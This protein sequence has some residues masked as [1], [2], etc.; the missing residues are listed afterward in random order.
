MS[1]PGLSRP[2]AVAEE[3]K[4]FLA[5][6]KWLLLRRLSQALV[7]AVF[8]TGPLAGI[9]IAKGNL[10]SSLTLGVLPLT[11]PLTAL[12][13][14]A[15]GHV[16]GTSA[17]IGAAVVLA[18][19]AVIGG[20]MYCSWI[21]PVNAVTDLAQWLRI[22]LGLDKGAAL[23]RNT[24][25]WIL[26]GTLAASA[27]TGTIAWEMVNPVTML[28]RG[29][30]TGSIL[31]FGSAAA[32][33]LAVFL[34]DLGIAQRGWCTHLCPVGAFYGLLGRKSLLRV[35]ARDRAACNDCMD[36]FTVC[37]E[38]HVIVPA[39]KGAAKGV[40]PVILSSDCTNCGRCIDVCSKTVFRFDARFRNTPP[41]GGSRAA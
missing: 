19:Y 41:E 22:R 24:R 38:R 20:R 26:A 16:M 9:W 32:I 34:F 14:L 4:G 3:T 40:G 27:V 35:S 12:Q 5:A 1:R 25:Y 10:A 15:A 31:T 7:V 21:C 18:V 33:T 6:R 23:D 17:L 36:C 13:S 29:L 8:L 11:D 39:L 2:G 30:V 37:P 28:H